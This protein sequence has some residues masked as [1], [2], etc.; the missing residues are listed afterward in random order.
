MACDGEPLI[1]VLWYMQ[2]MPL[3]GTGEPERCATCVTM[4]AGVATQVPSRMCYVP[5][6][7]TREMDQALGAAARAGAHQLLLAFRIPANP[8]SG[9]PRLAPHVTVR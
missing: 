4:L 8:A 7:E 3:E 9:S 1:V 2:N 5:P 6:F